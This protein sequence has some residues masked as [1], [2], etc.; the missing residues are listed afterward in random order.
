M[1]KKKKNV[2]LE[3]I[4]L[5]SAGAKGVSVG[6]TE[7]GKTILVSGAVPG[8]LV[9]ARMK[10][11]KKNY[12]EAEAIEILEE[13]PDRVDA[14][15]MHFSVCGGCKWQNLSYEK[16][17]EFKEDEV[18]NNIR[19]IGGID[20]FEAVPILGSAEQYFYRNKMEFSFSNARWL[21]L[22]E[23][24]STEEIADRNALGFHI[25][26]QWSK[27][28]DL[29]EC[30]LQEDP[31]NS[32][33]LAVK[34]Y[35][36]ENNLEFFDVRNQEG[37]LRTLMMRQNSKGEW[38]VLFQLFQENE[39][40][41]VKLLDYLL[42]K[43]PQIHTLLYAINPK[44]NDSI[45]DLD[46]QTYYGEGF[47]YEEMDGLRFKIGPK[48][49]FQT[50]YKQALELYRK[51]LE[52]ADLKGDE[53]V[54]D[55]YTGTGT[56]AQYVARNAKQVI[57]IEAVQEAIDAAKEH[58]ELNGLTNCTFYCGDMKDIFNQEFLESHPKADVL[59]TDPPRDG[60]HAKVVEQILNLSPEKIVYVSCNSATQARD[61]AML[62]EH[63][64]LVKVLPVDM[65]PQT[66]HV[67]N[68][69]LLI[70]KS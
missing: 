66:H 56:I 65:F 1:Q 43:F 50:N 30:F 2:I 47:L 9:N 58:A 16:Q 62:K 46:I 20:G 36:E 10:K 63:Y 51:T 11:S 18:L 8:D 45:Y 14:R 39:T 57:G 41:R 68:I 53:V 34:E 31:S 38:M 48:S 17:L 5:L 29:K 40:E 4:K 27:I 3:N 26:G 32:I 24:N 59:I 13:S 42:Q 23:V 12:I 6:K 35:A 15:C 67:E 54:Y 44:G 22:E 25:P 55:L 19:R 60:M 37:F 64:N 49:F 33:R 28:L 7:D 70:K 21:T 69:A 52:F 61:L